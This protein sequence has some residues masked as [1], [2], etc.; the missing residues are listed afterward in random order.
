MNQKEYLFNKQVSDTVTCFSDKIEKLA[1]N[2]KEYCEE[3]EINFTKNILVRYNN[4]SI[5]YSFSKVVSPD[6]QKDV[7]DAFKECFSKYS[8]KAE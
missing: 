8:T 3:N 5:S 4:E 7:E 1:E 2:H 6:I